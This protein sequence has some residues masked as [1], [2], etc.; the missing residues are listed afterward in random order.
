MRHSKKSQYT[1]IADRTIYIIKSPLNEDCFVA[2]CRKDLL[3]SVYRHHKY[4]ERNATT[5][6]C[7]GLNE[8]ELHPCLFIIETVQCTKVEAYKHVIV[9]AKI[10]A[11]AGYNVINFG[12]TK[13]FGEELLDE[14][15]LRYNDRKETDVTKL[16]QCSN[17]MVTTYKR[18][19]CILM[20]ECSYSS[21]PTDTA[22]EKRLRE[23]EI[24]MR[25][26]EEEYNLI[27]RNAAACDKTTVAYLRE[28]GLN[29][30]IVPM[31][32]NIITEHTAVIT[33][34]RNAVNQLIFTIKK[35]GNYTPL[36]LEYILDKTRDILNSEKKLLEL[37]N[38]HVEQVEKTIPETVTKIVN[39]NLK[40]KSKELKSSKNKSK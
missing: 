27:K 20:K 25:V 9:W 40:K 35:T 33:S 1:D 29:M 21:K 26:S 14:N 3:M 36:D 18:K 31:D 5:L 39:K 17:C 24:R 28:L 12:D 23:N 30:C 16:L 19:K 34:Y 15:K 10:I 37:Y 8:Q 11:N 22:P 2:H 7:E 38:S 32:L 13:A 6:I 4:C